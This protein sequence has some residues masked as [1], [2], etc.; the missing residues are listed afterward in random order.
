VP[1]LGPTIACDV[2]RHSRSP[3]F[4]WSLR[5]GE[6]MMTIMNRNQHCIARVGQANKD[7]L[8]A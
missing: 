5:L 1:P 8:A 3:H 6:I 2:V 7:T 4:P